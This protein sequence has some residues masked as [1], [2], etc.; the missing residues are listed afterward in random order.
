MYYKDKKLSAKRGNKARLFSHQTALLFTTFNALKVRKTRE[1]KQY[2]YRQPTS[3]S[4]LYKKMQIQ[5]HN[6]RYFFICLFYRKNLSLQ[7]NRDRNP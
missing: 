7:K 1:E 3:K 6:I 2:K 4:S 5:M